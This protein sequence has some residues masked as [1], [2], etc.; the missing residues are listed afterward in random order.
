VSDRGLVAIDTEIKPFLSTEALCHAEMPDGLIVKA[1]MV[2]I[3]DSAAPAPEAVDADVH[4]ATA[5]VRHRYNQR[6]FSAL[7]VFIEWMDRDCGGQLLFALHR[8]IPE[9][10]RQI[11][12]DLAIGRVIGIEMRPRELAA[13]GRQL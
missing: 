12:P 10:L 11:F 13:L 8:K 1:V 2:A 6:H 7:L 3:A 4:R 5:A 9:E